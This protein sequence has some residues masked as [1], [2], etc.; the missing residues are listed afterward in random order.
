M[1]RR[2]AE[3]LKLVALGKTN[4]DIAGDLFISKKTVARH[5]SNIFDKLD[6]SSRAA[7]TAYAFKN[8]LVVAY[9]CVRHRGRLGLP[10]R[11]R[12]LDV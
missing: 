6:V 3:V 8:Q 2:E 9:K 12:V 11:G 7:A 10:Q 1:T 4:R 5:I